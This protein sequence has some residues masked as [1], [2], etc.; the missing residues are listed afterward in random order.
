MKDGRIWVQADLNGAIKTGI[1]DT[2][3]DGTA[4]DKVLAEELKLTSGR[5]QSATTVASE[6][7][8][9]KTDPVSFGLG[10]ASLRADE[11]N[12]VPLGEHMKGLDFILGFD[13]LQKLP[14]TIDYANTLLRFGSMPHGMP[15][16]F[17]ISE[18]IRPTTQLRLAGV[19][20]AALLDTGSRA[21]VS[22][23]RAWVKAN[24][25]GLRLGESSKHLVLGS[26]V[27][28]QRFEL[29]EISVGGISLAKVEAQSVVAD[30]GSFGDQESS[31]ATIG[32]VTM[33]MFAQIGVDGRQRAIVFIPR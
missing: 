15:A 1:L 25:V 28:S 17:T 12:I 20:L 11:A 32:N 27:E 10:S 3:S 16:P 7:Q 4:I 22:L 31:W 33:G 18:D 6:M 30:E 14:F 8:V 26:E 21:G 29:D 9:V 19:G 23:P 2:G 13:A 5:R 24:L